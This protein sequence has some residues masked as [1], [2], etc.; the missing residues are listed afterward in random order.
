ML[1]LTYMTTKEKKPE[2]HQHGII[3][4]KGWWNTVLVSEHQCVYWVT[5]IMDNKEGRKKINIFGI[6]QFSRDI[7]YWLFDMNACYMLWILSA[8]NYLDRY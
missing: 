2:G 6:E 1:A 5:T 7:H 3:P 8:T 4:S